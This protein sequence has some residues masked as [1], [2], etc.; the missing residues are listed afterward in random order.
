MQSVELDTDPDKKP[1]REREGEMC[2][3]PNSER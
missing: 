2:A 1:Y 3:I